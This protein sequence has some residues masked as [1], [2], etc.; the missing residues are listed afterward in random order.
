[1]RRNAERREGEPGVADAAAGRQ[2]ERTDLH[3]PAGLHGKGRVEGGREVHAHV[4][5]DDDWLH[6]TPEIASWRGCPDAGDFGDDFRD[7]GGR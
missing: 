4:T 7:D 2:G 6:T 1:M 3:Q 5:C